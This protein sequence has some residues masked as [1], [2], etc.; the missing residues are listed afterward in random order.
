MQP[1][2]NATSNP[3]DPSPSP[4]QPTAP[5]TAR[6][7]EASSPLSAHMP[8]AAAAA[9]PSNPA[10]QQECP[11]TPSGTNEALTPPD[12]SPESSQ[13]CSESS[14]SVPLAPRHPLATPSAQLFHREFFHPEEF[15]GCAPAASAC[16]GGLSKTTSWNPDLPPCMESQLSAADSSDTLC[17]TPQPRQTLPRPQPQLMLSPGRHRSAPSSPMH[18]AIAAPRWPSRPCRSSATA[19][20]IDT[21]VDATIDVLG[22]LSSSRLSLDDSGWLDVA[23]EDMH[24]SV[25]G[26]ESLSPV[27]IA[28]VTCAHRGGTAGA[29]R[30]CAMSQDTGPRSGASAASSSASQ[31]SGEDVQ[32]GPR[33]RHI[34]SQLVTAGPSAKAHTQPIPSRS[35]TVAAAEPPPPQSFGDRLMRDSPVEGVLAGPLEVSEG[36]SGSVV[37][38]NTLATNSYSSSLA[39]EGSMALEVSGL[40][41][42][43]VLMLPPRA[44]D[45]G[46]VRPRQHA[47]QS[48]S[49][50]PPRRSASAGPPDFLMPT[51]D[52]GGRGRS[53]SERDGRGGRGRGAEAAEAAQMHPLTP[54]LHSRPVLV[55]LPGDTLALG[56]KE[57]SS[58]RSTRGT[59]S[60][61]H[62]A[63]ADGRQTLPRRAAAA[64]VARAAVEV[65]RRD[66]RRS[67]APL[68]AEVVQARAPA[69][70]VRA[71]VAASG[72][73]ASPRGRPVSATVMRPRSRSL[74]SPR[75][76]AA[77]AATR[78]RVRVLSAYCS[79][80]PPPQSEGHQRYPRLAQ[81]GGSMLPQGEPHPRLRA[82]STDSDSS[83]GPV[84]APNLGAAPGSARPQ[85]LH[86]PQP[87]PLSVAAR[88]VA[89]LSMHARAA[90]RSASEHP[91]GR[92]R[93]RAAQSSDEQ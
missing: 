81:R 92:P 93:S 89:L 68:A 57:R 69:A 22:T 48:P 86:P 54:I 42:S 41:V 47:S 14:Q 18:G 76:D 53:G 31:G 25:G 51:G 39:P 45:E 35:R 21:C 28:V 91:P 90:V 9:E 38:G 63:A 29:T 65:A 34:F 87:Q 8:P 5:H 62:R 36:M 70:G 11:S 73:P 3:D 37:S 85:F 26:H 50:N 88:R 4:P 59:A 72:T 33:R 17:S 24:G 49:R 56:Y 83:D 30:R 23:A 7:A 80:I 2:S 10:D 43:A 46:R 6:A 15:D 20:L 19:P 82:P 16:S 66:S 60:T 79:A 32:R 40:V 84:S 12:L 1:C 58:K 64:V 52:S 71:A 27:D 55:I 67:S 77:A 13:L 78:P 74:S 44:L 61:G 75:V